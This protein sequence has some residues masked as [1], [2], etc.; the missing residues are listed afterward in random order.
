V[1]N[2]SNQP[3]PNQQ[4]TPLPRPDLPGEHQ[5]DLT[6]P[7]G[8]EAALLRR[9]I[10]TA[11]WPHSAHPLLAHTDRELRLANLTGQGPDSSAVIASTVQDLVRVF[12]GAQLSAFESD[13]VIDIIY[14]LL[15]HRPLTENDHSLH[16]DLSDQMGLPAGTYLQDARHP[17]WHS[18]DGGRTWFHVPSP[19]D[20]QAHGLYDKYTIERNDGESMGWAFVLEGDDRRAW[21]ALV[22]YAHACLD[23][24]YRALARDLYTKVTELRERHQVSFFDDPFQADYERLANR[25]SE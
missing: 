14:Q 2:F 24:G 4:P 25:L 8:Q 15:R 18:S 17:A 16:R 22:A 11:L 5:V 13:V 19:R 10:L 6:V 12:C 20:R 23:A 7:P 3:L 1:T 9:R 21:P